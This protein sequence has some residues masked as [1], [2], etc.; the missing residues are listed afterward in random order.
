MAWYFQTSAHDT[1]DWDS[2]Q[3]PILIDAVIGGRPRKVVSTA[4]RNGYFYTV[5]RVTGEHLVTTRYGSTTNWAKEVRKTDVVEPK[6]RR[7]PTWST[8]GSTC[9][10]RS[11]TRS[12]C[13]ASVPS[14]WFAT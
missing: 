6:R 9:S 3:T 10:S 2:A 4:A 7:R 8:A 12:T 14:P 11:A 1:Q 5:D 13:C